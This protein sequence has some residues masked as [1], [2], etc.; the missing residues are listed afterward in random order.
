MIL[1]VS[2]LLRLVR[3]KK[4]V[5][6]LSERELTNPEGAGFDLR[7]GAL[8]RVNGKGFLGVTERETPAIAPGSVYSRE[9]SAPV[10][11][12]NLISGS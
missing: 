2:E 8:Y 11:Q 6:N 9:T 7:I 10:M 1:G 5:E 3:E 12:G 4:L